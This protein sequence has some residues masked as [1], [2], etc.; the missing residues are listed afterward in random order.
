M[1]L[2]VEKDLSLEGAGR[3][4]LGPIWFQLPN[5]ARPVRSLEDGEEEQ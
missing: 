3:Y 1:V 5:S 4:L 2:T